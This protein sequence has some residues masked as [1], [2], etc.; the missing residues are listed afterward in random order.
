MKPLIKAFP[1]GSEYSIAEGCCIIEL[2]QA[3]SDPLLSI[4]RARVPSGTTTRW[5][6]LTGTVERYLVESGCGLVEVGDLP[7]QTVAPGDVVLIPAGCRQ[8]ITAV[9]TS[10]LIFLALCTPPFR[11]EN[12]RDLE[13]QAA[14]SPL[15]SASG[16]F[17]V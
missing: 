13:D 12:Y 11:P 6:A 15:A 2:L 1:A 7:P 17:I 10:D 8:R 5:H 14:G 4:A 9:G 3:D 16:R